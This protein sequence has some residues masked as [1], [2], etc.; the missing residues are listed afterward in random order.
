MAKTKIHEQLIH[1]N[2]VIKRLSG[3]KS[4]KSHKE[5]KQQCF[6]FLALGEFTKQAVSCVLWLMLA[7]TIRSSLG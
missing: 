1:H 7:L 3:Q 6:K 2:Q 4:P 5:E